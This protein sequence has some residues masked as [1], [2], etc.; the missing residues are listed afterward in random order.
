MTYE[1]SYKHDL[2]FSDESKSK[3]SL[4]KSMGFI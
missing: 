2:V 1:F 3:K 4:T